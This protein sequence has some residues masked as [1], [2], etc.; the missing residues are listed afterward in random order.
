VHFWK[1]GVTYS[2]NIDQL[3]KILD[4]IKK[5]IIENPEFASLNDVST[6]VRI[7]SFNTSSIDIM[8]YCFTFTTD[9]EEW[10]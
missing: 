4:Q 7:D 8:L 6:S 9:W 10:L 2:T 5:Y 3:R 1:I